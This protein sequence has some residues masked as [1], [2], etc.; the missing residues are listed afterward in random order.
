[1]AGGSVSLAAQVLRKAGPNHSRA[2]AGYLLAD[3]KFLRTLF[4]VSAFAGRVDTRP[5]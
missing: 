3:A 5:G 4:F 2:C 1:M